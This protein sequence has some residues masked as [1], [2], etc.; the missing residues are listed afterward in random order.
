MTRAVAHAEQLA[1]MLASS[2]FVH[3]PLL[4][5]LFLFHGQNWELR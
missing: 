4:L 3:L 1:S 2:L 5:L